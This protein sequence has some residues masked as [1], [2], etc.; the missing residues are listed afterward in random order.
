MSNEYIGDPWTM[1]TEIR[2]RR[3][4]NVTMIYL[5]TDE[6]GARLISQGIVP[7]YL[8]QQASSALEWSCT[9]EREPEHGPSLFDLETPNV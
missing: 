3:D 2:L 8:K 1:D 4:P 6:A 7:A 9:A 5:L